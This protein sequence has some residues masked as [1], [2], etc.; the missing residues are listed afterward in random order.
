MN[1]TKESGCDSLLC[2]VKPVPAS[3]VLTSNTLGPV[4][5]QHQLNMLAQTAQG[6]CGIARRRKGS[7]IKV[8]QILD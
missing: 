8:S 3:P 7:I 1:A 5:V 4:S 6:V 2:E